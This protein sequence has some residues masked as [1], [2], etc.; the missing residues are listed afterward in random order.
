MA[1]AKMN[2]PSRNKTRVLLSVTALLTALAVQPGE[3]GSVDTER[4]LQ[5]THSFW[6]SAPPVDPADYPG[7]GIVG[8]N[9]RIYSWYGMGQSLVM[10]PPDIA[11]TLLL[12]LLPHTP[13]EKE[14]RGFLVS[15]TISPLVA[16]LSVLLSFRFLLLL[17]F[18]IPQ[19]AAGALA[20]LFGTTFLHYTQNMMENNLTLLLTLAALCSYYEWLRT[21]NRRCAW[22]GSLALGANL[23]VRLTTGLNIVA[24]GI[25]IA[26]CLGVSG[27]KRA[28]PRLIFFAKTVAA[29][30]LVFVGIDRAY[31]FYRFGECCSNYI[32]LYGRQQKLLDPTLPAAFPYTTP[33]WE[34]F[35]GP[36]IT[37]EKSIFLFDPL[38]ILCLL[39]AL[40]LWRRFAAEI[41]YYVL[42]LGVISIAYIAVHARFWFWSGDVAWGDRYLT[43]PVHLLALVSVPLLLRHLNDLG[44]SVRR[45]AAS[46]VAMTVVIQLASVALWYPLEFCQMKTMSKPVFVVGLRFENIVALAAGTMDTWH[47]TNSWTNA[48]VR[49]RTAYL[50]P[51]VLRQRHE[52][53]PNW[54]A[55]SAIAVW[56]ALIAGIL[57][58]LYRIY[59][60]TAVRMAPSSAQAAAMSGMGCVSQDRI[61]LNR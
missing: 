42:S 32:D 17:E 37:L 49:A 56:L 34:G 35:L 55:V 59:L 11:A 7:F 9:N 45:I 18:T 1:A 54:L 29:G 44:K 41:T 26:L 21:D 22:M 61:G 3:V 57:Y 60:N 33:F 4:R 13:D 19:S 15:F 5:T 2:L 27:W 50:M 47:L 58:S 43:T 51:F 20:L 23:L 6:T 14:W 12:R 8:R 28:M 48:N 39:L 52:T 25:F 10:L 46:I 40:L 24:I 30:T 31:H 38:L 53:L 16:V 36:L